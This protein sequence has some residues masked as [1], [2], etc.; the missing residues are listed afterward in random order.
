LNEKKDC[1]DAHFEHFK[2]SDCK[3]LGAEV[4]IVDA[5]IKNQPLTRVQLCKAAGISESTF[6]R[7]KRVLENSEIIKETKSGYSLKSYIEQPN[8]WQR[9]IEDLKIVKGELTMLRFYKLSLIGPRDPITGWFK[10]KYSGFGINGVFIHKGAVE[11]EEVTKI[12]F[13]EMTDA[14]FL[15]QALI[16]DGDLI[17]LDG[18][19]EVDYVKSIYEGTKISYRIAWL[20]YAPQRSSVISASP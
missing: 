18:I 8:L 19:Y 13:R 6:S 1:K 15:T 9:L 10:K 4:K 11:L 3:K 14:V 12:T 5:L 7:H 17:C 2:S 16:D 20:K